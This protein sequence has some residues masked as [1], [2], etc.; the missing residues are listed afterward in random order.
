MGKRISWAEPLITFEVPNSWPAIRQV[1]IPNDG[2]SYGKK[3]INGPFIYHKSEHIYDDSLNTSM[4]YNKKKLY[5]NKNTLW[6]R[7]SFIIV[8]IAIIALIVYYKYYK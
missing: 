5:Q 1:P 4:L 7:Y 2:L 3:S 6:C 8:V